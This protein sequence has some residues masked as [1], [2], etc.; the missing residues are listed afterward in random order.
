MLPLGAGWAT[1]ILSG[2]L[3][4]ILMYRSPLPLENTSQQL[5]PAFVG[6]FA[7]PALLVNTLSRVAIPAQRRFRPLAIKPRSFFAGVMTGCMGGALAA[8]LPAVTGGVGSL[9]AGHATAQRDEKIFLI[10]QGACKAVYYIGGVLLFFVPG[11]VLSRG[12]ATWLYRSL[13]FPADGS[14]ADYLLVLGSII[15]A[16]A[17]AL[18]MAVPLSRSVLR[19]MRRFHYR[20]ISWMALVLMVILVLL[21]QGLM[22]LI[23]M[24]AGSGIGL[25]PILYGSRRMNALG[26]VLL[27]IACNMCGWGLPVAEWLGL[28]AP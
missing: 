22:G 17:L 3:G 15:L 26:I 7:V 11:L 23:V 16:T 25:L 6:L 14:S 24:A 2:F 27:P 20:T 8:F 28:V 12:G 1:F 9:L 5:M 19:L 10:A 21:Q 18:L 13:G 4:F